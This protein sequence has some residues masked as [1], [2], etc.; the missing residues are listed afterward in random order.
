MAGCNPGTVRCGARTPWRRNP[1]EVL[2]LDAIETVN[3]YAAGEFGDGIESVTVRRDFD[4]Y[5]GNVVYVAWTVV[6]EPGT[7]LLLGL[8]LVGLAGCPRAGT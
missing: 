5:G 2:Y 7:A 1:Q 4:T 3:G 8:G 6:P